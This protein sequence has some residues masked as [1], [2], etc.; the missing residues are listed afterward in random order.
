LHGYVVEIDQHK[1]EADTLA[2]SHV[3]LN[4]STGELPSGPPGLQTVTYEQASIEPIV[5]GSHVLSVAFD[6]GKTAVW[7]DGRHLFTT[8][9]DDYRPAP[10]TFGATA[11]NGSY[12][13]DHE[14]LELRVRCGRP[15]FAAGYRSRRRISV[16]G[17]P[18]VTV[19]V[20]VPPQMRMGSR[21]DGRD[22]A[23]YLGLYPLAAQWEDVADVDS[24]SSALIVRLPA[25]SDAPMYLYYGDTRASSKLTDAPF[26][27]A[28]RFNP[29]PVNSIWYQHWRLD[30]PRN[31]FCADR[32]TG[33]T[34]SVAG[35]ICTADDRFVAH[36]LG[37]PISG[38]TSNPGPGLVYELDAHFSGG[39]GQPD[40]LMYL[41]TST[42]LNDPRTATLIP[43]S[44]YDP[45]WIPTAMTTHTADGPPATVFG[46]HPE[47][48]SPWRRVRAR[49]LP[50]PQHRAL[51]VRTI[52]TATRTS[53]A[54]LLQMDDVTLRVTQEPE[55]AVELGAEERRP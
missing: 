38:L 49:F 2:G 20:P 52:S 23:V 16:Q 40:D 37:I 8:T 44:A 46:F 39:F 1:N 34:S 41:A 13:G 14:V 11:S 25:R 45:E 32:G 55:I 31:L 12:T 30:S 29:R 36:S 3:A 9:I 47:P 24:A 53:T 17:P 26:Q 10:V 50:P 43:R 51:Q 35:S 48:G 33:E 28:E 22:V 4:R 18:G 42:V 5:S 27:L 19:R 21:H 54:T 15:D 7:L 6:R